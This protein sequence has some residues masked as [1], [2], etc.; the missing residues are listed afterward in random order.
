QDKSEFPFGCAIQSDLI[1]DP[2]YI[3]YQDFFYDTFEWG[4]LA[5]KLKWKQ[6][7]KTRGVIDHDTPL[8]A[9]NALRARGI[10]IRGH[11]VFWGIEKNVPVWQIPLPD[12][13][14]N[15]TNVDRLNDI[16]PTTKGLLE[17][18]DVNNEN[19]HGNYY[20][21]RTGDVNITQ[22]MFREIHKRDPDVKL[23][24]NDFGIVN[25]RYAGSSYYNQG[26]MLKEAGVPIYGFGIQS[27]LNNYM[28]PSV[29]KFRLD[30]IA[31]LGLPIWITELDFTNENKTAQ[32]EYLDDVMRLYFSHPAV[33]GIM[34]WGFW[35]GKIS[36][37]EKALAE[38]PADNVQ[39]TLN[40]FQK[41]NECTRK[42]IEK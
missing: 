26:K 25:E 19:V 27:H 40:I 2:A 23:F 15:G 3:G 24:L 11:A 38:G 14:I 33:E 31:R 9:I 22:W 6:M 12:N 29:L 13:E 30:R 35:I 34:L 28:E 36:A 21:E 39:V 8:N 16:I 18:W 32:A 7:E 41:Q 37:P 20:E 1:V 4:V 10:K 5:N 17:H 42:Q